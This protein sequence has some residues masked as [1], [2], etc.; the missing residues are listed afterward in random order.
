MVEARRTIQDVDIGYEL[1][2]LTGPVFTNTT[3]EKQHV[4][5]WRSNQDKDRMSGLENR[6]R[7][8]IR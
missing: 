2:Y 3:H 5:R 4:G 7:Y 8:T 6:W 1:F